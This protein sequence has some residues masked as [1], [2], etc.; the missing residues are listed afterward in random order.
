MSG[1]C[2]QR[3]AGRNSSAV[4]YAN[5]SIRGAG[6]VEVPTGAKIRRLYFA[7]ALAAAAAVAA[8]ARIALCGQTPSLGSGVGSETEMRGRSAYRVN[9]YSDRITGW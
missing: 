3:V 4:T 7:L 1:D 5:V 2:E 8:V 9:L 6:G